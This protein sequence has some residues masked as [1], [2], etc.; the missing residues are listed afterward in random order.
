MV[1]K[2]NSGEEEGCEELLQI[3]IDAVEIITACGKNIQ[4]NV[5]DI[6]LSH[7]VPETTKRADD[8]LLLAKAD[9]LKRL[10]ALYS[11]TSWR[12]MYSARKLVN[13]KQTGLV[14]SDVMAYNEFLD[15]MCKAQKRFN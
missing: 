9:H 10:I 11:S 6:I 4:E 12:L 7:H 8:K 13:N 5:E 1:Y 3:I 15:D 14:V 2:K